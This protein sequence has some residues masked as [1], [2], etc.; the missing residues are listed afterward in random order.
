[1]FFIMYYH[2]LA[3][4]LFATNPNTFCGTAFNYLMWG[5]LILLTRTK[6]KK[7]NKILTDIGCK[8]MYW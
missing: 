4:N 3:I 8:E 6:L 7:V 1:M 2:P 5:P